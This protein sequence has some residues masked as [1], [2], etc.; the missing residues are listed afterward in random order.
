MV[1]QI[2][3]V[4]SMLQRFRAQKDSRAKLAQALETLWHLL[5]NCHQETVRHKLYAIRLR[6][7]L[8]CI[9]LA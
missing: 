5:C 1:F 8:P 6:M 4:I 7:V 9:H 2:C 3:E